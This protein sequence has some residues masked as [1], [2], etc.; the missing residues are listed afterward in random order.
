MT[1][2]RR[3]LVMDEGLFAALISELARRGNGE[4]ETGAFLLARAGHVPDRGA[5]HLVTAVAYYDDL[6]PGSL[7][8][9]ITFSAD[10][11]TALAALCRRD[12]LR[13][14]G[15]IHTHPGSMIMQS[16]IDTAHP[17]TAVA[18]HIALIAPHYAGDVIGPAD[19]GAHIL[20][21]G[22]KWTSFYA[23]DAA[24]IVGL[25]RGTRPPWSRVRAAGRQ[26]QRLIRF[27]RPR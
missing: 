20:K 21:D 11:Y 14:V 25:T 23:R 27:R 18:G 26:L 7:T 2:V 15:D 16:A 17:M 3:G 24:R 22:G 9:G 5:R 13:V 12:G 8:G 1:G 10:G 6:D 19:L 4:R